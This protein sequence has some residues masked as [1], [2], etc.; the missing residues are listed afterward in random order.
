MLTCDSVNEKLSSCNFV[1]SISPLSS[2]I[3]DA[4]ADSLSSFISEYLPTFD[5]QKSDEQTKHAD[6]RIDSKLGKMDDGLWRIRNRVSHRTAHH[7][8]PNGS[9]QNRKSIA[10]P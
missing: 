6:F 5:I 10:P 1:I 9:T 2:K 4:R 8:T 7:G 3:L